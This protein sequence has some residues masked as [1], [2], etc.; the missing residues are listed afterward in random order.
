MVDQRRKI[1]TKVLIKPRKQF[2]NRALYRNGCVRASKA[3]RYARDGGVER[4]GLGIA[5]KQIMPNRVLQE[6]LTGGGQM[7]GVAVEARVGLGGE[8]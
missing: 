1:V 5:C 7:R 2:G 6:L 8:D 3:A 4:C